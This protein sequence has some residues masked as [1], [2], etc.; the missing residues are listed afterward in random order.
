MI[1]KEEGGYEKWFG[2]VESGF[3]EIGSP[4]ISDS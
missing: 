1:G 2:T 3:P 4:R